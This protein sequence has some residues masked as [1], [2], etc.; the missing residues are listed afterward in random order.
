MEKGGRNE[1]QLLDL[2]CSQLPLGSPAENGTPEGG[3]SS[4]RV[5]EQSP[6]SGVALLLHV[7]ATSGE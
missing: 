7:A 5:S 2:W 4:T 1:P 3:E 6:L